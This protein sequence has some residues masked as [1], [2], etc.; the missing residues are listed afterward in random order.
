MYTCKTPDRTNEREVTELLKLGVIDMMNFMKKIIKISI[1][2]II[3]F[4]TLFLF[5][6]IRVEPDMLV[7]KKVNLYLPNWHKEHSALKI[8][9]ISDMHIGTKYVNHDKVDKIVKKTNDAKPDIIFLMG[10]FDSEMIKKSNMDEKKLSKQLEA[11]N[12]PLGVMAVYGNHDF[13]PHETVRDILKDAKIRVLENETINIDHKGK[14]LRIIGLKDLWQ[15]ENDTETYVAEID[16]Q[17]PTILLS[18]NPDIFPKVP[19]KTSLTLSGHI[20]GGQITLP[21]LGGV[22]TA[23]KYGQRY[24][25]GHIVE[26]G[27]HI[28]VSCGIGGTY[29]PRFGNPPE[30]V[31]IN[32]YKQEDPKD[33]ILNTPPKKGIKERPFASLLE[34]PK[35]SAPKN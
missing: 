2:S 8:A 35:T 6:T 30:V 14:E 1:I 17:N 20:H 19:D 21:F 23:S 15:F 27:K 4:I 16:T 9:V 7:L 18:H 31:I 22:F 12:A 32:A 5:W 28:Y 10:D 34:D 13:H 11:L 26:N 29:F 24:I 33:F 25:K 3:A